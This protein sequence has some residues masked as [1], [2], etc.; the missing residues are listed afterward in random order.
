MKRGVI[1]SVFLFISIIFIILF[2]QIANAAPQTDPSVISNE[3]KKISRYAEDYESGNINYAQLLV[4]ISAAKQ[5]IN[6]VLHDI[7]FQTGTPISQSQIED[8]LGPSTGTTVET[9]SNGQQKLITLDEPF[10]TW[11]K[12][13]FDG[14]DIQVIVSVYPDIGLKDGK[15]F[16]GAIFN[17]NPVFKLEEIKTSLSQLEDIIEQIKTYDQTPSE[18]LAKQ[19][20]KD[21]TDFQNSFRTNTQQSGNC[22]SEM[23]RVFGSGGSG[24]RNEVNLYKIILNKGENTTGMVFFQY[25]D[26]CGGFG[27]IDIKFSKITDGVEDE[28]KEFDKEQFRDFTDEQYE[29][30][31]RNAFEEFSRNPNSDLGNKMNSLTYSWIESSYQG[32]EQQRR[33]TYQGIKE[34][35]LNLFADYPKEESVMT[36]TE[37][38]KEVFVNG[39]ADMNKIEENNGCPTYPKIDCDGNVIIKGKDAKGCPLEPICIS[40]NSKCT[41]DEDCGQQ[42]CGKSECINGE[43][44]LT[45]FEECRKSECTDGDKD[46]MRCSSGEV[47]V[48]KL[49]SNGIWKETGQECQEGYSQEQQSSGED[50]NEEEVNSECSSI[51]DCGSGEVCS[52]GK[53]VAISEREESNQ[54][55]LKEVGQ[56]EENQESTTSSDSSS[57]EDKSGSG[58]SGVTANV[59]RAI[60]SAFVVEGEEKTEEEINKQEKEG[61]NSDNYGKVVLSGNCWIE[62]ND[63]SSGDIYFQLEGKFSK[64]G[65]AMKNENQNNKDT[66]CLGEVKQY[67]LARRALEQSMNDDFAK[68]FFEEYLASNAD[69]WQR[70]SAILQEIYNY[71]RKLSEMTAGDKECSGNYKLPEPNLINLEYETSFGSFK[72]WER[73]LTAKVGRSKEPVEVV[74]PYMTSWI[75]PSKDIVEQSMINDPAGFSDVD[76]PYRGAGMFEEPNELKNNPQLAETVGSLIDKYGNGK[77]SILIAFKF[78]DYE[79]NQV[80]MNIPIVFTREDI[81]MASEV[82]TQS[83]ETLTPDITANADFNQLYD[84]IEKVQKENKENFVVYPDYDKSWHVKQGLSEFVNA[85]EL[86]LKINNIISSIETTPESARSDVI[87]FV[88]DFIDMAFKENN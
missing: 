49:C 59:I 84:L 26:D 3:I 30:E 63:K 69:Q 13:V 9:W 6:T 23:E 38:S 18:E 29:K 33:A 17:I 24:S 75:F 80:I 55:V 73:V 74:S 19:I 4:Y 51:S 16:P 64:I 36:E 54:D 83:T 22:E 72:F 14:R 39:V 47:L 35:Y 28:Q 41:S 43:C 76:Q 48:R 31:I 60:I 52:N 82:N 77:D 8:I 71:D 32:D 66:W 15:E 2:I 44:R 5:N 25:C 57:G 87:K 42:L 61:Q 58:D 11:E 45:N 85:I 37:Y 34:F 21:I 70:R 67:I 65:E 78:I 50:I 79:N 12:V 81:S 10:P 40:E 62:A 7:Y 56:I 68:W 53:C 27:R 1:F 86:K 88:K 20:A 46:Y